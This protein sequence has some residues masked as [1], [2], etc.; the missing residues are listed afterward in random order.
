MHGDI[1]QAQLFTF[2]V[3]VNTYYKTPHLAPTQTISR[4]PVCSQSH[5]VLWSVSSEREL[6]R[7]DCGGGHR[8]WALSVSERH[9]WISWVAEGSVKHVLRPLEQLRT[10]VVTV[11]GGLCVVGS[12]TVGVFW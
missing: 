5:L 2:G 6:C 10:T 12:F 8:S 4:P 11:R 1:L 3:A 7:V 9:L